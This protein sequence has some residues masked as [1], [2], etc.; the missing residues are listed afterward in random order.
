MVVADQDAHPPMLVEDS[1]R[2]VRRGCQRGAIVIEAGRSALPI[3]STIGR[4]QSGLVRLRYAASVPRSVVRLIPSLR[5]IVQ[6]R[7]QSTCEEIPMSQRRRVHK[8][9]RAKTGVIVLML[10][11]IYLPH[12]FDLQLFRQ[13]TERNSVAGRDHRSQSADPQDRE[14]PRLARKRATAH[15]ATAPNPLSPPQPRPRRRKHPKATPESGVTK[16]GATGVQPSFGTPSRSE[17]VARA[18]GPESSHS[19]PLPRSAQLRPHYPP[20]PASD[21]DRPPAGL[22][23]SFG[24]LDLFQVSQPLLCVPLSVAGRQ[25]ASGRSDLAPRLRHIPRVSG[26]EAPIA[27]GV[28]H[29]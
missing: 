13:R 26:K 17:R 3:F 8:W 12:G 22:T 11:A 5:E 28:Q 23:R 19:F 4:Y 15:S 29:G 16:T 18:R 10:P 2:A 14:P 25:P 1:S 9:Q 21:P 20:L 27:R 24:R 7:R 6:P